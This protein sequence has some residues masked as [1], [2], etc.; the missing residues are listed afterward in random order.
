MIQES[1]RYLVVV[2]FVIGGIQCSDCPHRITTKE[3]QGSPHIIPSL[4]Y[5]G[6]WIPEPKV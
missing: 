3:N 6:V 4:G 2:E 1:K 5:D